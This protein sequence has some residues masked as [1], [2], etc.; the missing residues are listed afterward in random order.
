MS[1]EESVPDE[2]ATLYIFMMHWKNYRVLQIQY[3]G[4][5]FPSSKLRTEKEVKSQTP[6]FE[7]CAL[8]RT[9]ETS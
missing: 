4:D 8:W 6:G 9:D 3:G 5:L 2:G 7:I 1:P